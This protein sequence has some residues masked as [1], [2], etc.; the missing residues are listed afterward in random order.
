MER[1]KLITLNIDLETRDRLGK[2]AEKNMRS[3]TKQIKMLVL[4]EWYRLFGDP[5]AKLVDIRETKGPEGAT[6]YPILIVKQDD[7]SEP[8]RYQA[9]EEG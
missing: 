4:D 1:E 3:M 7:D 2:I 9:G 8:V 6:K 5:N